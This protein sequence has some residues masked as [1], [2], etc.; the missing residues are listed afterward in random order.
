MQI[1]IKS[2]NLNLS[3]SQREMLEKKVAKLQNLADRLSDESTEFRVE[4]R[5]EKARKNSEAYVCQLTIF[6]P[7]AVIRAETRDES[8]ENAIDSCMNKIKGQIDKYKSKIHRSAKKIAGTKTME[9]TVP[10]GEEIELPKIIR[11]K[12]F[13][14]TIPL[15]EDEAIEKMELIGHDFFIFNNADTHRYS[16]VYKRS[17][18]YYGIIEPKL[19]TD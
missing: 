5:H 16:M 19:P 13:S 18:G 14:S 15:K 9:E 11:R 10:E 7:T 4:V 17:D 8:I 2:K 12:R 6:A 3:D 1:K